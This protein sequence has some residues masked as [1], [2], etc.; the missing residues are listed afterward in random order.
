M[1]RFV[2][3]AKFD[4]MDDS[5]ARAGGL[6]TRCVFLGPKNN[7]DAPIGIAIRADRDVGDLVAGRRSFA[8]PTVMAVLCG[9]V[10]HDG[11]WMA[12]G[13]VYVS[14][15]D[16]MSGDLLFGPEGGVIFIMFNK[17]SG[18]VPRFEDETDQ[19]NFDATMRAEVEDVAAGKCEKSVSILPPRTNC[20][21][22]R[23]IKYNTIAEVDAYRKQVGSEW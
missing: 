21:P 3:I 12:P 15:A 9:T 19:K 11:R 5:W 2:E 4:E 22:G 20:T 1:D 14:P 6:W 7:P 13:D 23:A 8:T 10:M 16:E 18:I 17:R